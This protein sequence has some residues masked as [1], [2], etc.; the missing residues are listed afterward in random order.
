MQ[1]QEGSPGALRH[2]IGGRVLFIE[3]TGMT[4]DGA[5]ALSIDSTGEIL[6]VAYGVFA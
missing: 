6:R 5:E 1:S 2:F 4:S 3:G